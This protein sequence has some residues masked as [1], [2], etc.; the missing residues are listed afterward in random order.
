MLFFNVVFQCLFFF[1]LLFNVVFQREGTTQ[2]G[3]AQHG[4]AEYGGTPYWRTQHGCSLQRGAASNLQRQE[5]ASCSALAGIDVGCTMC[6]SWS[7]WYS[8]IIYV[9]LVLPCLLFPDVLPQILI[10]RYLSLFCRV[11]FSLRSRFRH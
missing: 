1:M 8:G 4:G 2:L 7:A 9:R 3:G 5:C 11:V 10:K 6:A